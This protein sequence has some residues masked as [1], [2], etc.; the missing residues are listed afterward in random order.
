MPTAA[1]RRGERPSPE[2]SVAVRV[3]CLGIVPCSYEGT[4]LKWI[5]R[6]FKIFVEVFAMDEK[7]DYFECC[8]YLLSRYQEVAGKDFYVRLFPNNEMRGE[9]YDDFSHPNAIYLYQDGERM[10]QGK[11]LARRIMLKDTWE[12]DY[13]ER[14]EMNPMTL[15]SGLTYRRWANK[16]EN[17]QQMNALIFDLDGVGLSEL[18]NLFLRFGGEPQRVRRLPMP[19]FLVLSGTGL[20]IYYVF[21]EPIDLYPNIK[22]Q[23]KSLKYDL[24]F[25]MWEYKLTSKVKT[26]QYQSINQGF[27]MVGSMNVK[28]GVQL[29]AFQVGEPITLDY[30]NAYV[31]PENRVDINRP[32]RPSKMNREEAREAYPEWYERVIVRGEKKQR[33]WNIAGKVHG[34]DPYALYHWW[35]QQINKVKGGH[36]YYFMMCLVIYA[37][38]CD[39]SKAKLKKDLESVYADLQMVE[40]DN[41]L[42]KE[43][44]ESALEAYDREYCNFTISDIEA[45]TDIRIERNKRNGRLQEQH[46]KIISAVRDVIYPDGSW[47]NMAGQPTKQSLVQ[48]WRLQHPDGKPRECIAET[49][50]S[51]NTVYKWWYLPVENLS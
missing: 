37:Y 36:R 46:M 30:L 29:R 51:K 18:R 38:K 17:A 13:Q 23:L 25:R 20:H 1:G 41:I 10:K 31:S 42:T 21:R 14:I 49:G 33:K 22:I 45:L 28:H 24:T 5:C 48:E 43:D 47:R 4:I 15:C 27:R 44:I 26:I 34:D 12:Q 35:L 8:E 11:K 19:T 9:Y 6:C 39:V 50:L 32:F 3:C 16:L 40:H 2:S 7:R